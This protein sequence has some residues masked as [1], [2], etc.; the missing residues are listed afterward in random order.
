MLFK[1]VSK[2]LAVRDY[3]SAIHCISG[4]LVIAVMGTVVEAKAPHILDNPFI[5]LFVGTR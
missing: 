5:P 2:S 3:H 4:M 1:A